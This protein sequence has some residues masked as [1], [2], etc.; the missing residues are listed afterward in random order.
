VTTYTTYVQAGDGD[1]EIVEQY[2]VWDCEFNYVPDQLAGPGGGSSAGGGGN[3]P[4]PCYEPHPQ[5]HGFVVPCGSLADDCPCCEFTGAQRAACEADKPPCKE[6]PLETMEISE[7][8]LSVKGGR[9][10]LT[11]TRE[12]GTKKLHDGL[13]IKVP[14]GTYVYSPFEGEVSEVIDS[15]LPVFK[16]SRSYGNT[17]SIVSVDQ[18]GNEFQ[19]TYAHLGYVLVS[20]GTQISKGQAIG[21][22]GQTGNVHL[23]KHPH[24]HVLGRTKDSNGKFRV[25]KDPEDYLK[26]K[27]DA[28]GN[29]TQDPCG[30]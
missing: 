18:N 15:G 5:F 13:D 10:G 4:E 29:I 2:E 8:N 21:I 25:P 20:K 1:P 17:V 16:K 26:T 12:D 28:Q 14:Y 6:L 23:A 27:Y 30:N 24:V 22:S 3:E 7:T 11:R 19:L 9:F